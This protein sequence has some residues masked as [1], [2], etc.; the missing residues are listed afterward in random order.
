MNRNELRVT[1]PHLDANGTQIQNILL[2][3][4]AAITEAKKAA[5]RS[6]PR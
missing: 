3:L 1:I 4:N 2:Q 6:G 5:L